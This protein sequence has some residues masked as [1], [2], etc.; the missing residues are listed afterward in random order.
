VAKNRRPY[1]TS[2]GYVSALIYNDKH[3]GLFIDAVKPS[4][5]NAASPEF[6]TLEQRA[7]RI[8]KVYGLLADTF[9]ERSTREWL[10]LF[11][12]LG[13]PAA[14]LRTPGELFDDAHLEAVGFFE[15]VESPHGPV[16]FPGVPAWLSRT[17]G[18]VAGPAPLLGA[19]T[20]E[21]F[22]ELGVPVPP[23]AAAGAADGE[24]V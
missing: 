14:P 5:A 13:I 17:Q 2:D 24:P 12:E 1:R 10:D 6:A 16:R 9:R 19:H 23:R 20:R 22:E 3:W 8:D 4:W 7:R 11:H 15:T 18:R 21:V